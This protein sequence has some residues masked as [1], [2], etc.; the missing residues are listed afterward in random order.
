MIFLASR[1][2]ASRRISITFHHTRHYI[3]ITSI[4]PPR[5][6]REAVEDTQVCRSGRIL[7]RTLHVLMQMC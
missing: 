1:G 6:F 4:H 7:L 3:S 5:A 2:T